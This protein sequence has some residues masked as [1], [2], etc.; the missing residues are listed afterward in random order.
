MRYERVTEILRLAIDLRGRPG[1]LT[2]TDIQEAFSVSRRTAERMHDAVEAAFGPLEAVDTD[3]GDR[4]THWRL[5]SRAL[6][7]LIQVSPEELAELEAA[8]GRLDRAGLGRPSRGLH[9][10]IVK[11]RAASRRY[12]PEEFAAALESLMETE[13]LAMRPGPRES[14]EEGLLALLRDAIMGRREIEFDYFFRE[15][16][17]RSR[18]RVQPYGVLYGNRAFLV[19]RNNWGNLRLWRLGNVSDGRITKE[20]FDYDTAFDL[21]RYAALSFG[22]FQEKPLDVVL[23]FDA[24]VALDAKAFQFHPSQTIN[25]N[26]DGSLTVRFR[27]G[28]TDEICWHLVTW[29]ESVTILEP[30]GLRQRLLEMC[31]SLAEHHR[32]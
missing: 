6:H 22:T 13:G 10:L 9:E 26:G 19:A 12:S 18:Q 3:T 11:L 2:I 27:A 16:G 7:P 23:R 4:R 32:R 8:A 15:S 21:R 20:T 5:K 24:E 1:G 31:V 25:E 17:Q 29:E 30:P 14:L 28:G